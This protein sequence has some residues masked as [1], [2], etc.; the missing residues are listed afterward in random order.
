VSNPG[1]IAKTLSVRVKDQVLLIAAR[2]DARLDNRK[3]N[4]ATSPM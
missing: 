1:R 4:A 3:T 2:G